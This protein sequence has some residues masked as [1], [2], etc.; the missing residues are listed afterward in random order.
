MGGGFLP[1]APA[2]GNPRRWRVRAT[3]RELAK[4]GSS[5]KKKN[6]FI[7][8]LYSQVKMSVNIINYCYFLFRTAGMREIPP[9]RFYEFKK[10]EKLFQSMKTLSNYRFQFRMF[11]DSNHILLVYLHGVVHYECY[12]NHHP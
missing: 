2:I 12:Q 1:L 9:E 8:P 4:S 11:E 5:L 6:F 7:A 10:N 3:Q